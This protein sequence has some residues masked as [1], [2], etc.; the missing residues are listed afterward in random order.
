MKISIVGCGW[1]GLPLAKA[2]LQ[3]GFTVKGTTTTGG[4]VPLLHALGIDTY[5]FELSTTEEIGVAYDSLFD[6][7]VLIVNVPPGGR[8]PEAAADYPEKMRQLSRA[9]RPRAR[10]NS[11]AAPF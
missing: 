4:K 1:L 3:R 6:T 7:D 10:R 9:A 5:L 2:A 11:P 8:S